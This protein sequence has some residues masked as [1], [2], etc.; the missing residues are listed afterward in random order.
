MLMTVLVSLV[1]VL[2]GATLYLL[3]AKP[4]GWRAL[5]PTDAPLPAF[6]DKLPL[7]GIENDCYLLTDGSIVGGWELQGVDAEMRDPEEIAHQ[8]R[9]L[10]F[11]LNALP[12]DVEVIV[13]VRRTTD[14]TALTKRF[15][16]ASTPKTP[17]RLFLKRQWARQLESLSRSDDVPF[18]D[19]RLYLFVR[20]GGEKRGAT[21]SQLL[22]SAVTNAFRVR[23]SDASDSDVETDAYREDLR[24]KLLYFHEQTRGLVGQLA[25]GPYAPRRLTNVDLDAYAKSLLWAPERMRA[26]YAASRRPDPTRETWAT[27]DR[28][29]RLLARQDPELRQH[30]PRTL[31]SQIGDVY[32]EAFSDYVACDGRLIGL[33]RL[34]VAPDVVFP[35]MMAGFRSA[36]QFPLTFTARV[37][38]LHKAAELDRLRKEVE[39]RNITANTKAPGSAELDRGNI[40]NYQ[41][42]VQRYDDARD[43]TQQFFAVEITLSY[44]AKTDVELKERADAITAYFTAL[45]DARMRREEYGADRVFRESLPLA[46]PRRDAAIKLMTDE[47]V[48][49]LPVFIPWHGASTPVRIYRSATGDPWAFN[50]VD[51]QVTGAQHSGTFGKT[52]AGKGVLEQLMCLY[53]ALVEGSCDYIIF[54]AGGTYKKAAAV[55]GG[56]FFEPSASSKEAINPLYISPLF[57]R[58]TPNDQ[59]DYLAEHLKTAVNVTIEL[60]RPLPTDAARWEAVAAEVITPL[61]RAGIAEH[62][63]VFLH[64]VVQSLRTYSGGESQQAIDDARSL[65]QALK[66]YVHD[67]ATGSV[68]RYAHLFDRPQS[69]DGGTADFIVIDVFNVQTNATLLSAFVISTLAGLAWTRILRNATGTEGRFTRI[70]LDEIA[71]IIGNPRVATEVDRLYRQ[72]R[73]FRAIA[74]ALLQGI[75]DTVKPDFKATLTPIKEQMAVRFFLQHDKSVFASQALVDDGMTNLDPRIFELNRQD[76]YFS[77][78]LVAQRTGLTTRFATV[79]LVPVPFENWLATTGP[80][81]KPVLIAWT[82]KYGPGTTFN[83]SPFELLFVLAQIWPHGAMYPATI[84]GV[85]AAQFPPDDTVRRIVQVA[86]TELHDCRLALGIDVGPVTPVVDAPRPA[87][88]V[89]P[90]AAPHAPPTARVPQGAPRVPA[91]SFAEV[92]RRRQ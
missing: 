26:G 62:R 36:L 9:V 51:R 67:E 71:A 88:A 68:G 58:L 35:G 12:P 80:N 15:E 53:P 7:E 4:L 50:P 45:R 89:T 55:L 19:T 49:L 56:A 32:Y 28:S 48:A 3:L 17:E 73:K 86:R 18:L 37:R 78:V 1:T 42:A 63:E 85:S 91:R 59:A 76:G 77:D 21:L 47:I 64:D 29:L 33:M 6:A 72:G 20:L 30:F 81:D 79:P 66:D 44:E 27:V 82:A 23:R 74:A 41:E 83:L 11:A 8:L 14:V 10:A 34:S 5:K 52:G 57:Y 54:D 31:R 61:I 2:T 13:Q 75:G 43:A 46:I 70:T 38:S 40:E 65:A 24:Q 39:R 92:Q 69:F 87:G 90:A 16:A 60:A 22:V 84:A 25:A